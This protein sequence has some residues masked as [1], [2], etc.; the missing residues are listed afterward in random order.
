MRKALVIMDM[1]MDCINELT[2]GLVEKIRKYAKTGNFDYIIGTAYINSEN[3]ACYKF[4]GWKK[5]MDFTE[6]AYIVPRLRSIMDVVIYKDKYSCWHK[7][8]KKY[9][10]KHKID[11]LYFVGVSTGC[12]VLNS[13]YDA[14]NDLQDCAVVEDLCASTSS[15]ESHNAAIRLLRECITPDRVV[16]SGI[17][18]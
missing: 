16:K 6:G 2:E 5:C 17:N 4:E 3:T 11:K 12:C 14:Y 18:D 13:A 9:V 10:K 15:I 1:Q 7:R 8:F